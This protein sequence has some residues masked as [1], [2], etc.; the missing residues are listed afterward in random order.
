[1]NAVSAPRVEAPVPRQSDLGFACPACR[2]PLKSV[3]PDAMG[4]PVCRRS[5]R[6]S[7]GIWCFLLPEREAFF[8]AFLRDYEAIRRAEGRG[9]DDPAYY[10]SL[11]F[12]DRTGRFQADWRIRAKSFRA[13]LRRVL[14]PLERRRGRPLRVL[15]LGAGNGWLSYRLALRGHESVA[16]DLRTN[17]WD[18]LG[19][20]VYYD[21]TFLPV[22]AEFDRLPFADGQFDLVVFNASLHYSTD[23][24]VT[25]AEALRVLRPDGS[26]VIMDTPVYRR[27][28]SGA[29]MVRERQAE[30]T[31]KYGFPSD[32]LPSEHY[33]TEDRLQ[34]LA[35]ALGLCWSRIRPFYGWR[36]ALR[37]W[38]ALLTG[39][40][41]PARFFVIVGQRAEGPRS[42][43]HRWWEKPRRFLGRA[44]ARVVFRLFQRHR[45]GRLVIETVAGTP[46]VVLPGVFNPK[47]FQTGEFLAETLSER[48]V[49]PGST[50]L[51]MGTGSGVGAVFAARWARRVV[52]VDISP[53]AVRC[54]RINVLLHGLED[55]VE[56]RAGDLFEPVRGE[57]FDVI[58]FNPPYLRGRP[59]NELER[60]LWATDV[61]ERFAA[62][63]GDHLT[64]RGW[65]LLL[66][67]S[68]SDEVGFLQHFR[69]RG[70]FAEPIA[71]RRRFGEVW[72]VYRIVRQ[73]V[74]R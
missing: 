60:A 70:F 73:A 41:E 44:W 39:H 49:P 65:A 62:G 14:E 29:Q 53:T 45:Y 9:S 47:L 58:L 54:A 36:W 22:Q 17:A 69:D 3:G 24:V 52:A 38:K 67:S 30:F 63:L 6:R 26:I 33:L 16:V 68:V 42:R 48:W 20:H 11:P 55:R 57:R 13:F 71:R 37:P 21:A 34:G 61:I 46:L 15:D 35:E 56:V 23:Y 10:R 51:D 64:D 66:L 50:V 1:M 43:R 31:R 74:G 2:E 25:L 28:A 59:R 5:Y 18:G 4:C 72:T 32:A 27:A 8:Q 7:D 19:A 40:R 12:E